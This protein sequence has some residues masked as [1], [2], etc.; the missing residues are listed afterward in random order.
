[1]ENLQFWSSDLSCFN[2]QS[3]FFALLM[4]CFLGC[5]PSGLLLF[6][7]LIGHFTGSVAR[8][9]KCPIIRYGK[10]VWRL[11]ILTSWGINSLSI[12]ITFSRTLSSIC[13]PSHLLFVDF[14]IVPMPSSQSPFLLRELL[15]TLRALPA[16]RFGMGSVEYPIV[17]LRLSFPVRFWT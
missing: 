9:S 5:L 7:L 2:N 3:F 10:G 17:A 8:A 14:A 15:L 12:T 13:D 16:V 11:G 1:V 6:W 4:F